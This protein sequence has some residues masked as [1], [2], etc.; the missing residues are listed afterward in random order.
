MVD[1]G[2]I[3]LRGIIV[4]EF[5]V[6]SSTIIFMQNNSTGSKDEII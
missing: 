5:K 4:I 6:V 2:L 1:E 3:Y